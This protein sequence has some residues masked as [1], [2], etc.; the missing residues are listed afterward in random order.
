[1]W[2]AAVDES[3]V[4]R[5][6][7]AVLW[8]LHVAAPRGCAA[9]DSSSPLLR[10][11][12]AGPP[13]IHGGLAGQPGGDRVLLALV[14]RAQ[15]RGLGA[16][17][18]CLPV[19]C[20]GSAAVLVPGA[21][22]VEAIAVLCRKPR[23]AGAQALVTVGIAGI[24]QCRDDPSRRG[25]AHFG[26]G[27]EVPCVTAGQSAPLSLALRL[28]AGAVLLATTEADNVK[29]SHPV[30]GTQ[31]AL[32]K[33]PGIW[34]R[35]TA[36]A[37]ATSGPR[38]AARLGVR[39]HGNRQWASAQKAGVTRLAMLDLR[40]VIPRE[41]VNDFAGDVRDVDG[42]DLIDQDLGILPR[43]GNLRPEDRRLG[44]GR[45]RD[46]GH[47]GPG[48]LLDADD[49]PEAPAALLVA[50]FGIAKVY[51]V[52]RSPDHARSCDLA[53]TVRPVPAMRMLPSAP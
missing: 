36:L 2:L 45:G 39:V 44:A 25:L 34:P 16:V 14:S 26:A 3:E 32:V 52:D 1:M 5:Q 11:I 15:L 40:H 19:S 4:H 49:E 33:H 43:D 51:R 31:C 12:R 50:T 48:V 37:A 41:I 28:A 46:N 9:A 30:Q 7:G 38:S 17:P 35:I 18:P 6:T 13:G 24:E 29:V 20:L 23:M 27:H 53:G 47:R 10:R 22:A 21:P 8:R 42:A